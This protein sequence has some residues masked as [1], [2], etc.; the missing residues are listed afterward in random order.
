MFKCCTCK[1]YVVCACLIV[2]S[3]YKNTEDQTTMLRESHIMFSFPLTSPLS[4]I[5]IHYSSDEFFIANKVIKNII[6]KIQC[7]FHLWLKPLTGLKDFFRHRRIPVQSLNMWTYKWRS[8]SRFVSVADRPYTHLVTSYNKTYDQNIASSQVFRWKR[9]QKTVRVLVTPRGHS[10]TTTQ[11]RKPQ[12]EQNNK[13]LLKVF[14]LIWGNL[15]WV[16]WKFPLFPL[17]SFWYK[18]VSHI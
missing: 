11:I 1:V 9:K 6:S 17:N 14:F 2:I 5:S 3:I 7:Y 16:V 4:N 10:C 18:F 8:T 15:S 12:T 13:D